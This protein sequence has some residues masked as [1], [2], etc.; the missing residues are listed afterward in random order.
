M[1][2]HDQLALRSTKPST[3]KPPSRFAGAGSWNRPHEQ[4]SSSFKLQLRMRMSTVQLV[5]T[6]FNI[7]RR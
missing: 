1:E 3:G 4:C 7:A 2:V 6:D 5:K